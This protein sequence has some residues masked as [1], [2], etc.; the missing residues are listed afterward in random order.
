V[1][2]TVIEIETGYRQR[3]RQTFTRGD[4]KGDRSN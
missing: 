2:E 3:R 1:I 4:L